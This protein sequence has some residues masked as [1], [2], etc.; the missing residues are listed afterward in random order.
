MKINAQTRC[1]AVY[2]HPVA[3]SASPSMHNAAFRA[4]GLNCVYLA[5]DVLPEKLKEAIRG[6]QE[7]KFI[8]LNLTVPHKIIALDIVDVLDDSAREWGAVNTIRFDGKDK[9]G[10]W[11][12]LIEFESELPEEI[13]SYGFNTDAEAI[14]MALYEDFGFTP[15]GATI[16]LLGTGGAGRV[17]ALKLASCGAK[18]LYLVNRTPQKALVVAEEIKKK[19]PNVA[20]ELDYP[21]HKVDLVINATSLGLKPSDLLPIDLSRFSLTNAALAYDMIYRPAETP[22]L[23]IAKESGCKI[24]NGISMLLWQGIRAFEIWIKKPAPK[25]IMQE[26]LIKNI[27]YGDY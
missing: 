14:T 12:P 23:K 26:A 16:L 20:V 2:G 21:H 22:L 3:H 27:Y 25:K 10:H 24:A 18:R 4:L 17:A 1:C 13:R 19:Y 9:D 6:A 5:F 15:Q 7:M 11:K 8:G